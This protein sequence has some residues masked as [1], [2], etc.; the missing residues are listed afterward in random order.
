MIGRSFAAAP[1]H[2]CE[3]ERRVLRER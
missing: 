3:S 1:E 2:V